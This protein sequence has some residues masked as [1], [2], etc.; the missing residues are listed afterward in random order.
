MYHTAVSHLKHQRLEEKSSASTIQ[1]EAC[2]VNPT[3]YKSSHSKGLKER[4]LH[5]HQTKTK[6]FIGEL[7]AQPIDS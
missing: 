6:H 5:I 3:F 2:Q 1:I 4:A 7:V